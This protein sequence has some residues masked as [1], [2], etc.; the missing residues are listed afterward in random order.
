MRVIIDKQSFLSKMGTGSL[1]STKDSKPELYHPLNVIVFESSNPSDVTTITSKL[2]FAM[3]YPRPCG[4]KGCRTCLI[5]EQEYKISK[6]NLFD[7]F[8]VS[9]EL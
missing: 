7:K 5:C 4:C 1:K 2:D 6:E 8:A 9:G 3:D